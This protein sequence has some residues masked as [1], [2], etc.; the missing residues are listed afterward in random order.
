MTECKLRL[1]AYATWNTQHFSEIFDQ[2]A[3][4]VLIIVEVRKKRNFLSLENWYWMRSKLIYF[5][6]WFIRWR[7]LKFEEKKNS[8]REREI[9]KKHTD[10]E[11]KNRYR[12]SKTFWLRTTIP[13][14]CVITIA[15]AKASEIHW[16][17]NRI[18][19]NWSKWCSEES[20]EFEGWWLSKY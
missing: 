16:K 4:G 20:F 17:T 9:K 7:R 14:H 2:S 3:Y 12:E 13:T 18:N 19:E 11:K 6:N 8:V 10:H 1:T 15:R 5:Y